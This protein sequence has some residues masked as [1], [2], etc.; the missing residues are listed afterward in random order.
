[1]FVLRPTGGTDAIVAEAVLGYVGDPER[2]VGEIHRV[3]KPGVVY[4]ETNF[5]QGVHM[6]PYDLTRHTHL[7]H[8]RLFRWFD[9]LGSGVQCGPGMGLAWSFVWFAMALAG[10]SKVR[11]ALARGLA[12]FFVFWLKYLDRFLAETPGGYDAASGTFFLGRRRAT[13][14]SD[15]EV[16]LGY[17][18]GIPTEWL[19]ARPAARGR[20]PG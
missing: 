12:P 19:A 5:M 8:R 17:R 2:V 3:L 15:R 10:R 11:R 7:G 4:S 16:M 6:G 13:P 1:V 9:E 20:E 18:G 14:V